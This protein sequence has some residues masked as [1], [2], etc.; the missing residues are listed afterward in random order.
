MDG[1]EDQAEAESRRLVERLYTH[2]TMEISHSSR[3]S[4]MRRITDA[5]VD[6]SSNQENR[7]V[8]TR[9]LVF[10]SGLSTTSL[11]SLHRALDQP[12]CPIRELE[13]VCLRNVEE[14]QLAL[15]CGRLQNCTIQRLRLENYRPPQRPFQEAVAQAIRDGVFGK[16]F[17]DERK[18]DKQSGPLP[19][20]TCLE[21]V[22]YP[23]GTVGA[24]ILADAVA[25]NKEHNFGS[26]SSN[27][28]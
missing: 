19:H 5:L 2:P 16:E 4:L 6:F 13:F 26:S 9:T 12:S 14:I 1:L 7:P 23:I 22:G 18:D 8:A 24:Q 28:L 17:D 3:D 21:L 10:R 20:L 27:G 11:R 25:K 15:Q